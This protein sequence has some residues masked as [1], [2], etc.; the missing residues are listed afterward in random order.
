MCKLDKWVLLL[1]NKLDGEPS[2]QL[3]Q[4]GDTLCLK[5][6]PCDHASPKKVKFFD[7]KRLNRRLGL[8]SSAC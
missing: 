2:Q 1:K 8:A 7:K 6:K 5:E 3:I 4:V